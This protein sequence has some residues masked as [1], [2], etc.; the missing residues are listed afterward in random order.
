M[1]KLLTCS[2]LN[3]MSRGALKLTRSTA[4]HDVALFHSAKVTFRTH[5]DVYLATIML[6]TTPSTSELSLPYSLFPRPSPLFPLHQLARSNDDM[7]PKHSKTPHSF[8]R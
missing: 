5:A 6:S 1:I 2:P 8:Q 4:R 7:G 3:L